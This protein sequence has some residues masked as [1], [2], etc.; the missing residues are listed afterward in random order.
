MLL[1]GHTLIRFLSLT[2]LFLFSGPSVWSQAAFQQGISRI[3]Q[4]IYAIFNG[5]DTGSAQTVDQRMKTLGVKG[6]SVAVFDE[7]RI[8]WTRCYGLRNDQESVDSATVFQAAS[9]SKPVTS[10]GIFRLFEK[11]LVSPDTDINQYLKRWKIPPNQLTDGEQVTLRRI[12]SHMAGITVGGFAGYK[13]GEPVPDLIQILDGRSPANSDPIRLYLRPGTRESY[14][15]GA[16]T[17]LQLLIEEITGKPFPVAMKDL[18]IQPAGMVRSGFSVQLPDAVRT[19]AAMG[20][21]SNGQM[22]EGGYRR[23]PEQA[24]AGLWT[25]PSEYAGFM[26]AV[27]NAY[28]GTEPG[29]ILKQSTVHEM[30]QKVP[31]GGGLGFGVDGRADSLRYRHSGGNVG[32]TCYAVAFAQRG[33]GVVIMTNSDAGSQLIREYLRSVSREYRWP[34]MGIRE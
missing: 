32:Y 4:N 23:H 10:V 19:N 27:G 1:S 34:P 25:T 28:R 5:K 29:S 33:R 9:L 12:V 6:M 26:L 3:E 31:G 16:F 7:G 15:G 17:V 8:I 11:G 13:A 30:L 24:A 21:H 2:L 22:I 20:F 14:S 18:V